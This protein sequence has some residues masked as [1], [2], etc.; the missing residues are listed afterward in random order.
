MN[1]KPNVKPKVNLKLYH[2]GCPME[3]VYIDLLGPLM[4]SYQGNKYILMMIDQ[5][6]KWLD[7]APTH[8]LDSGTKLLSLFCGQ[9]WFSP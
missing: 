7:C 2:A 3:R 8:P 6:T 1:K 9:L 5:F 4:A